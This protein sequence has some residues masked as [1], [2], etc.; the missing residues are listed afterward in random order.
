VPLARLVC[1]RHLRPPAHHDD[2][3]I[4]LHGWFDGKGDNPKNEFQAAAHPKPKTNE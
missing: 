3:A 4:A 2:I 1:S